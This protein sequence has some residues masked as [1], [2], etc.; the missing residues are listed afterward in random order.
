MPLRLTRRQLFPE[1]R[2]P[3]SGRRCLLRSA[4]GQA[5]VQI[6]E[7]NFAPLPIAIPNFVGRHAGGQRSRQRRRRGH[8]QQSQTQRAV[9]ADRSGRVHRAGHQHRRAAAI[10][11]LEDHQR[12]GAG[13][14]AHDA[15]GRR[16]AQG[17]I[18]A[19]G[20]RDR[21]AAR[22]PAI[23]HLAGI[24][25]A[26]RAHHLRPD[27][28]AAD[29]REGLFRQPRGVR[30]RDRRRRSAA[31]SGWRSWTRTAPMSAISRAAPTS[32]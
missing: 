23:F 2:R 9:R 6:T 10:P 8:H 24:L 22:R 15:A 1:W 31:S 14:G 18:P 3:A 17:R 12:A 30:R 11:E 5:R 21:P 26:D 29:R 20:R 7:G 4:F 25:A 28:R 27:L 13:D 19:L 32:C 16:A